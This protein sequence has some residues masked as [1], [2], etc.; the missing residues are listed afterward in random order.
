MGERRLVLPA[1][2]RN[3]RNPPPD[4]PPS[5]VA[6][7]MEVVRLSEE[8]AKASLAQRYIRRYGLHGDEAA[9]MA[10]L[11]GGWGMSMVLRYHEILDRGE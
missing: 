7:A 2:I 9:A 1:A 3:H 5:G 4:P 6:A 11:I 8:A 10:G